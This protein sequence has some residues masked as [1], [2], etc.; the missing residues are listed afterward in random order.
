[1][2]VRIRHPW[3]PGRPEHLAIRAEGH[4]WW[5]AEVGGQ[6]IGRVRVDPTW[7][8][9][10]STSIMWTERYAPP[11]R[12]CAELGHALAFF[13]TPMANRGVTPL[14]HRNFLADNQGCPGSSVYDSEG[15]VVQ[16]MGG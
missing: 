10:A 3:A 7:G 12:D 14:G 5:R 4:G 15:G 9:L 6:L 11:L 2:T 8:G 13:G 16:V 1:M